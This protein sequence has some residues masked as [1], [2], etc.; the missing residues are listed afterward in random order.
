M[1]YKTGTRT[2]TSGIY[3][4]V[5]GIVREITVVYTDTREI[6]WQLVRSCYG[7]GYWIEEKPWLDNDIWKDNK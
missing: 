4:L 3:A 6:I 7:K 2:P 5:D 1:I